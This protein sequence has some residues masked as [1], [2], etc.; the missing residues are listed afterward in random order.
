[1]SVY[2]PRPDGMPGNDGTGEMSGWY[3]F[4]S[5]RFYHVTPGVNAW[6]LSTPAF[7]HATVRV[8]P[9]VLRI[10]APGASAARPYLH[11]ETLRGRTVSRTYLTTCE[12]TRGGT[13]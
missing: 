10:E 11:G 7:P 6:A 8:G 3:V 2:N 5:L 9:R 12:L 1:M 4:A 13:L